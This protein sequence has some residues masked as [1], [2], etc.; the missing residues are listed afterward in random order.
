MRSH[1][2][3]TTQRASRLEEL[4][5]SVM[6]DTRCS[7]DAGWTCYEVGVAWGYRRELCQQGCCSTTTPS[8]MK[9]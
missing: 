7:P 4:T 5:V 2:G 9:I 1:P 6:H 8:S 3:V